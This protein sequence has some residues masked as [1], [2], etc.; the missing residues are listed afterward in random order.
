[1]RIRES[2]LWILVI[3]AI[4]ISIHNFV[5]INWTYKFLKTIAETQNYILELID[6]KYTFQLM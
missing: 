2:I 5:Q 4:V 6:L 1:M 3:V